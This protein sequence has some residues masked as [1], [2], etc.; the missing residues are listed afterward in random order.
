MLVVSDASPI[1]ILIR[2]DL[3]HLLPRLYQT[4]IVPTA[5]GR[6]LSDP[7]APDLIRA[8][9]HSPPE[10]V[11]IRAPLHISAFAGLG[12]GET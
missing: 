11:I 5:V 1:N 8:F 10:W 9:M 6:E 4:V 2:L 3:I 12:P 7:R